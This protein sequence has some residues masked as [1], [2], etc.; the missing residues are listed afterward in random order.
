MLWPCRL[1][2]YSQLIFG[3]FIEVLDELIIRILLDAK[4]SMVMFDVKDKR[5]N[6]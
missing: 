5:I 3:C 2:N 6:D 1:L 4:S